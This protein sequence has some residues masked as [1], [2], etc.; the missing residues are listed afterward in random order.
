MAPENPERK[1]FSDI[2]WCGGTTKMWGIHVNTRVSLFQAY[3]SGIVISNVSIVVVAADVI[4]VELI[5]SSAPD[6][7]TAP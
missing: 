6:V 3:D 7:A 2:V 4:D 5:L 1:P